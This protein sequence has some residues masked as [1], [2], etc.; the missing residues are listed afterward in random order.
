MSWAV[1]V[2]ANHANPARPR[3]NRVCK[4]NLMSSVDAVAFPICQNSLV[5]V[6]EQ[7]RTG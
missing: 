4:R 2:L 7:L 5:M 1:A 6:L 3:E